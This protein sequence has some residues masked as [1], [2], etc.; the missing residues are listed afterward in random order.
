MAH[1]SNAST[2]S[3]SFISQL[4][5]DDECGEKQRCGEV[6]CD[7]VVGEGD[8]ENREQPHA[9][10]TPHPGEA[11]RRGRSDLHGAEQAYKALPARG[12]DGTG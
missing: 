10:D 9:A 1:A 11:E 8:S 4:Q 6:A 12:V 3:P 7:G 2:N 5:D